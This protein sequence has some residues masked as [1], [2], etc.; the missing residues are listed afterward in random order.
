MLEWLERPQAGV[1]R[2]SQD[3]PESSIRRSPSGGQNSLQ[4]VP[5][6]ERRRRQRRGRGLP[7]D[8]RTRG[9]SIGQAQPSRNKRSGD[10]NQNSQGVRVGLMM[11]LM[12]SDYRMAMQLIRV[13]K[14]FI[15]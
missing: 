2:V 12:S 10:Q 11:M 14:S 8:G 5:K 1:R 6:G 7:Q 13:A 15:L 3:Y 9:A 4:A